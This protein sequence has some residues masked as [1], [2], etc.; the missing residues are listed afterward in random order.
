MN[1]CDILTLIQGN[2]CVRVKI[3]F[4][5]QNNFVCIKLTFVFKPSMF[6]ISKGDRKFNIY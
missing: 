5:A 1:H 2:G 4:N 3:Q 6:F